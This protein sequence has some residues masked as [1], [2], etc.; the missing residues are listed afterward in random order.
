MALTRARL[1]SPLVMKM[2]RGIFG[3]ALRRGMQASVSTAVPETL[4]SNAE[5]KAVRK[6][7][8]ESSPAMGA[9]PALL[10]RTS[11]WGVEVVR[12]EMQ[13][14]MEESEVRSSWMG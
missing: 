13:L 7:A 12:V 2:T 9:M 14:V 10:M 3:L 1:L 11:R 8:G 5:L 6:A 4:V